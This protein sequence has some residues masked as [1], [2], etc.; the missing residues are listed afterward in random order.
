MMRDPKGRKIKKLSGDG[1]RG[2][3]PNFIKAVRSRRHEDLEADIE[4]GHY[5]SAWCHLGNL[6]WQVGRP[7]RK[8]E[9]LAR[10]K[11]VKPWVDVIEEFHAHLDANEI[12]PKKADIKLGAMIE[13]D[14][15]GEALKGPSATPQAKA[16]WTGQDRGYRKPFVVPEKV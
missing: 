11:G 1:G 10:V 12:D 13:I 3:I 15:K 4:K 9:A 2:H 16:L 8:E 5:S 14:P 6:S 7:Y